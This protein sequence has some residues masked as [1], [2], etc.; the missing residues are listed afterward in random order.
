MT[1]SLAIGARF[2]VDLRRPVAHV[3][4]TNILA[5]ASSWGKESPIPS[6]L[7]M[8]RT[9]LFVYLFFLTIAYFFK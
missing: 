2:I 7:E 1:D 9:N 5:Y 6:S 4:A 8:Y 3:L